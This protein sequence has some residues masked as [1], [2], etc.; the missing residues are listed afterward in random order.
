MADNAGNTGGQNTGIL[1]G[2]LS[3]EV[4]KYG[5]IK[6]RN[7]LKRV[8]SVKGKCYTNTGAVTTDI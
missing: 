7:T 5:R 1:G 4:Q 3:Q 6:Y 8:K 2:F